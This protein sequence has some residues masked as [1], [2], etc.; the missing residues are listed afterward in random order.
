MMGTSPVLRLLI[1]SG[2]LLATTALGGRVLRPEHPASHEPLWQVPMDL[3]GWRGHDA[4]AF[5]AE[6]LAQLG[7][8]EY[9]NR[10][11]VA[12]DEPL[13]LY[14]GYYR[15]QR[16]GDTIH[17]P[18]N[19][20]PGAG[21]LPVTSTRLTVPVTGRTEPV[22]INRLLIQKGLDRQVVL[23]WYQSHGRVVASEYWSKI[24]LVTDAVRLN[25]S[26]AAIVR[27]VSPVLPGDKG[28]GEAEARALA[29][30]QS[31]FPQ[32]DRLLPI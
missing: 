29:F 9:L 20:L 18:Q 26:D 4:P 5:T 23:Y 32:I 24:Y 31:A 16:E 25:R 22:T 19:C 30:V 12:G 21:W 17:S 10:V 11:Y 1:L 7:V 13:S 28:D 15:S 27:I 3:G 8:D 14:V 2:C 6:V